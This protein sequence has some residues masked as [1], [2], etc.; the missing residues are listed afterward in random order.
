MLVLQ[1]LVGIGVLFLWLI[2]VRINTTARLVMTLVH[3]LESLGAPVEL[4]A[5]GLVAKRR[6]G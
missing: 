1:I 5:D 3:Q 4:G 2:F 6:T